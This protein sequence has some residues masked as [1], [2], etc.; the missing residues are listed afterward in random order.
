[1]SVDTASA[2]EAGAARD[3]ETRSSDNGVKGGA[4]EQEII[5]PAHTTERWLVWRIDLHVMP[6]LCIMYLMSFLDK[7]NIGNAR[8][9]KL[10]TDLHLGGTQFNTALTIFFVPYVLFEIPSNIVLKRWGPQRWVPLCMF[11]FGLVMMCQG[12]V[13]SYS[14]LLAAR[15]FLGLCEAGMFPGSFYMLGEIPQSLDGGQMINLTTNSN[16][17]QAVGV[18][19]A[20]YLVLWF[21]NLGRR[22]WRVV[23]GGNWQKYV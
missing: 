4:A 14:G 15:F 22:I 13:Q 5:C 12:F 23:G 10:E 2:I 21:Y 20:F 3:I 8:S 1:V 6:F 9:F 17:V 19:E 18:A 16:V 7:V 11:L